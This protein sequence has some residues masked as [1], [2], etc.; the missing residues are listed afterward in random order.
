MKDIFE[1]PE[2]LSSIEPKKLEFIKTVLL[3]SREIK[4]KDKMMHFMMKVMQQTKMQ[5]ITFTPDELQLIISLLRQNGTEE[6]NETI[7]KILSYKRP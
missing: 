6:E 2:A 3:E 1:N 4:D 5:N 7:N